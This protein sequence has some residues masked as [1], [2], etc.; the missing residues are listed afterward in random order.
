[1]K[2]FL[3]E[4]DECTIYPSPKLGDYGHALRLPAEGIEGPD[5]SMGYDAPVGEFYSEDSGSDRMIGASLRKKRY[6]HARR[7]DERSHN[8]VLP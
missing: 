4:P 3:G 1:M 2:V 6:L 7:N 5:V 8:F